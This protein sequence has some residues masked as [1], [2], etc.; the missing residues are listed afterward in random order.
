ML[1]YTIKDTIHI[2]T[3]A[4]QA[5]IQTEGYVSGVSAGT[6]LDKKTGAKDLGFGLCIVDFLLE[7]GEDEPN[8]PNPYHYGD[9]Y[10]GNIPKR[11]VELPQI[12]TQAKKL[13]Y[14]VVKTDDFIAVKQWYNWNIATYN[15]KT[16]SL[17]EQILVFPKDTR[18][19]FCTDRI[20]SVNTVENIAL[21]VDMPGHLKH[22]KGDSFSQIYLSYYGTISN[23]EFIEDFPPDAKFRYVR[24]SDPLPKRIIRAYQTRSGAW[25]AGMTLNPQD[26]SEA[27][28]HQRGYI[29]FIEELGREK[30]TEGETFSFAYIVGFF[31]SID[32]M[33]KVYDQHLEIPDI[34]LK[35]SS[36]FGTVHK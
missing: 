11:Y 6:L 4:L 5:Q 1:S 14:E 23:T 33:E 24:G 30:V 9:L 2:E 29:C 17:W 10:H 12:C 28:C 13:P 7:P 21:R 34:I 19:F 20:T 15:R 18:Y 31:D 27:W 3:D 22:N 26:V 35:A 32:E 8:E 16:G 25:L 36:L